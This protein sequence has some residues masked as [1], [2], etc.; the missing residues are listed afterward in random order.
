M[1]ETKTQAAATPGNHMLAIKKIYTKDLSFETPNSPD[2]FLDDWA[3]E[4]DIRMRTDV[5]P[6]KDN[7]S[8]VILNV[9]LT[10]RLGKRTA[11]LIEVHQA[12]IFEASGYDESEL[13]EVLAGQCPQILYPYVRETIS[14]VVTRGGFP[15]FIMA[16][17]NLEAHYAFQKEKRA[18]AAQAGGQSH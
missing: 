17:M 16:P 10:V 4:V 18:A 2:I 12:G 5:K 6:I 3:P 13:E 9:T 11:Y 1:S 15:P 14:D 7:D 8:E